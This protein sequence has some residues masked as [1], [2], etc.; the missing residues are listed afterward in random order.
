M[1]TINKRET[2]KKELVDYLSRFDMIHAICLVDSNVTGKAD[3]F[4][5]LDF[6]V[7]V[8]EDSVKKNMGRIL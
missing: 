3:M 1:F 7:I 6:T 4:S 5:D 2:I 8:K